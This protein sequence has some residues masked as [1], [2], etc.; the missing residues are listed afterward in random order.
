V[1]MVVGLYCDLESFPGTSKV[2]QV[3]QTQTKNYSSL[4]NIM[5]NTETESCLNPNSCHCY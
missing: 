3:F 4:Q 1:I 5:Q 2:V